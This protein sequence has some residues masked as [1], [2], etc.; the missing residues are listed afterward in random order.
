[1]QNA[2]SPLGEEGEGEGDILSVRTF[3]PQQIGTTIPSSAHHSQK[4]SVNDY[5]TPQFGYQAKWY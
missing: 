2:F 4:S 3:S 1:M 5:A